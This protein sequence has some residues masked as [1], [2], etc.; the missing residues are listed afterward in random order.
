VEDPGVIPLPALEK[1]FYIDRKFDHN[2]AE[3]GKKGKFRR[4]I[5][6]GNCRQEPLG[7]EEKSI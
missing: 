4:M 7:Q 3:K 2:G 6:G 5:A 1:F